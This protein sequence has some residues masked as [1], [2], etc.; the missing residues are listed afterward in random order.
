MANTPELNKKLADPGLAIISEDQTPPA[1]PHKLTPDERISYP[2][3]FRDESIYL[4][5][6]R[7]MLE[8]GF[9]RVIK[10]EGKE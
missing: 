9:K 2:Q 3:S 10:V 8:A 4:Q 6:Q 7:D 5:A 1:N